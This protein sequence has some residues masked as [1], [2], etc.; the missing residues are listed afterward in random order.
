M[1]AIMMEGQRFDRLLVLRL[2][3][4]ISNRLYWVCRCDC[5]N[6][7]IVSG[8]QLRSGHTR[9]CSCLQ[10]EKAA[11]R[12]RTHGKSYTGE[13]KT[14]KVTREYSAWLNMKYRVLNPKSEDYLNYGARGIGVCSRWLKSFA[15]FYN[16]IGPCPEGLE[17]DRIDVNGHYEPENCRWT[18]EVVQGRNKRDF[19]AAHGLEAVYG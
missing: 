17:L 18:N 16:D 11:A 9:S 12:L 7:C 19:I 1:K 6:E 5:G 14:R 3:A 8:K 15:N 4:S 13:R 10:K 2:H